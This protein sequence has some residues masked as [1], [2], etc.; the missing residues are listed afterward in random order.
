MAFTMPRNRDLDVVDS[1]LLEK[2][3]KRMKKAKEVLDPGELHPYI[4]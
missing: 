3:S 1:P 2:A 4:V